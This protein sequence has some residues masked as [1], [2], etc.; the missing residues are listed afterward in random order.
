MKLRLTIILMVMG[1]ILPGLLPAAEILTQEDF[2]RKTV[3]EEDLIKTA[4]NFLILFDTSNSMARQHKKGSPES[5]YEVARKI[6]R[7]KLTQLPNLGYNA[8]LYTYTPYKEVYPMAPL[9]KAKFAEAID[10]LPAEPKGPTFLPQGLRSIE[11]TLQG[12]SG[13]TVVYIFSDGTYSQ[14]GDFKDPEDYTQEYADKYNVCFYMIG[15]PQDNR[16]QK[17]LV[18]MSKANA[19]SRVIPFDRFVDNPEYT[20]G[21]LYVVKSTER[22]ETLTETKIVGLKV[23]SILFDFDRADIRP[24]DKDEIDALGK[25]LKNNPEA[26]V[27]LEGYTDS[28]GSDEYN[29]GLSLRR[30][31]NVAAYLMDNYMVPMERIVVNYYGKANPTASNATSEGRAMNRRVEVAVGG[32]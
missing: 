15:S 6:L 2:V 24:D 3:V 4:D 19:C 5:R 31:D 8:G 22:V 11:P 1:M 26:Y 32:L 7:D 20:T 25:F 10:S 13:K 28:V 18:D 9:D 23:N 21:A 12:L 14:M 30:A 27:L 17:R 29:L 16:A